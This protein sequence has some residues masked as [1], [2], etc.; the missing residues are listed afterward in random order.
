MPREYREGE[1]N[2]GESVCL[3]RCAAKF[4]SV[5]MTISEQMQKEAQQRSG[6]GGGAGGFFGA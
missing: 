1:I 2:K 5:H 6:A 4:F 3:D